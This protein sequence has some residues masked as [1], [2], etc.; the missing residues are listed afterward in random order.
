MF[1]SFP[2]QNQ[3]NSKERE[4]KEYLELAETLSQNLEGFTF[5]GIE[6][7]WYSK[8]KADDEEYPGFST[9]TDEIIERMKSEGIKIV[10]GAHPENGDVYALPKESSDIE[11]DM[12]F[13]GHLNVTDDMNETLKSLILAHKKRLAEK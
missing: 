7:Q 5:P 3:E 2:N 4:K 10:L 9:P 12:I 13:P 11:N 6:S 8:L 1:E